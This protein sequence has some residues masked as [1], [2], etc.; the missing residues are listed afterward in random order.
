[1]EG[2]FTLVGIT[3]VGALGSVIGAFVF[4]G[5]GRALGESRVRELLRSFGRWLL[6]SEEDFDKAL[7][8]FHRY[9][10]PVIFFGRMVPIVRSL[11]SIPAGIAEMRLG[12][13]ALYTAAGTALWSFVL[14][15]AGHW[16]GNG[17]PIVS[18][19]IRRYEKVVLALAVVVVVG[20][21]TRRLWQ[22]LRGRQRRVSL[23]KS[24][25]SRGAD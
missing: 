23:P 22:R 1:M 17:W 4:Y 21:I 6:L 18:D 15:I 20:F 12:R 5:G 19:W 10:E 7:S 25:D 8:W 16:L 14:A 9:G 3:F 13:F 11:V 24:R 2:R